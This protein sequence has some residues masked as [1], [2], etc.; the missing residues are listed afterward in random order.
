MSWVGLPTELKLN[1]LQRLLASPSPIDHAAHTDNLVCG[2]LEILIS[3]SNTELVKLCLEAYYKVNTFVIKPETVYSEEEVPK[4]F[5]PGENHT[6]Q[7]AHIIDETV[8][9][10]PPFGVPVP[11]DSGYA[12]RD[13]DSVSGDAAPDGADLACALE[14]AVEEEVPG[15]KNCYRQRKL[16]DY[17]DSNDWHLR[18][19]RKSMFW[20]G[21]P[22]DAEKTTWRTK[23]SLLH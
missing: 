15:G 10:S 5:R 19:Q 22:G 7:M 4:I 14:R 12:S 18:S 13:G 6:L 8:P 23:R 9:I 21:L 3:T 16:F 1:I 20:K 11:V 2:D 17:V